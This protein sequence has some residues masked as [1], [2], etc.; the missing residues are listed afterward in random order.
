MSHLFGFPPSVASYSDAQAKAAAAPLFHPG[1][2]A[3]RY[4]WS[5]KFA[6][7]AASAGSSTNTVQTPFLL[8]ETVTLSELAVA[9]STASAGGNIKLAIY[10]SD[11]TTHLPSGAPLAATGNL[12]T[13]ST[14]QVSG[15]IVGGNVQLVAGLYWFAWQADNSTVVCLGPST[16]AA[17]YTFLAGTTTLG[18]LASSTNPRLVLNTTSVYGT[19]PNLTSSPGSESVGSPWTVAFKVASVP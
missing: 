10:A 14:G 6:F 7:G 1:H 5:S 11:P 16:S 19:W 9:I 8:S 17:D 15:A 12:S 18:N 4:Y 2:V 13:T 3:G